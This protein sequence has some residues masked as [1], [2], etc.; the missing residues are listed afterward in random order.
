M[1][2]RTSNRQIHEVN[3]AK[4]KIVV[5]DGHTLNPGDLNW[6]AIGEMGELTVHDRT[7]PEEVVA[8]ADEAEIIFTNK[9]LLPA[10]VI[11][12]LPALK[13]IGVL[14]T[15]YNVVD[16]TAARACDISVTNTPAYGT[17]SVAQMTFA[18]I[19]ELTQQPALHDASVH[20]GDWT[21]CPDFCY[22]KKPLVE[23][24][25]LTLGLVGYG[26]I[27]QAVARLGRAFGMKILVHTRTAREEADIEFVDCETVFRESDV[28]SL[29]CP[30]TGENQGFVKKQLLSQMK[31]TAYLI[32]T[33]RGP[34]VDEA[35]LAKALNEE[36]IAGAATD[37]LSVEP[38]SADNPLFEVKNLIITPHI[39]WATRAARERLMNIAADN[40]RAFLNGTP[41][42][43]VN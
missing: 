14:A 9:T 37:V 13:Y 10:E 42:N 11:N 21:E 2:T 29:H 7:S 6:D 1:T 34:L 39:G 27:G 18:L 8:R 24:D 4:P 23:L 31:P 33:A 36:Q 3:D 38:P 28:V 16:I 17:A 25:G 5:L 35:D 40:L 32:N 19:L 41:Q 15:G 12:A 43:V 26:A 20:A 30:L 22:W